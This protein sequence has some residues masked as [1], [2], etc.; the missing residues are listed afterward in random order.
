MAHRMVQTSCETCGKPRLV[1][2]KLVEKHKHCNDCGHAIAAR[3]SVKRAGST[4]RYKGVSYRNPQWGR[5]WF[6]QIT[7]N[8]QLIILGYFPTED[9]AAEAY[10][11]AVERL[12]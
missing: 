11:R 10:K 6:S 5:P 3:T 8:K 7:V 4:S 9:D 1:R 12:T 2:W